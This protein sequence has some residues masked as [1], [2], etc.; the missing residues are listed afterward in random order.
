MQI[1][2]ETG[3]A[4]ILS[5]LVS[6]I[7]PD[8]DLVM[9]QT[10][11]CNLVQD[12]RMHL[13]PN[14]KVWL[15]DIKT[16]EICGQFRQTKDP[17]VLLFK[18]AKI[19]HP[20]TITPWLNNSK[21][22]LLKSDNQW[23]VISNR[24]GYVTIAHLPWYHGQKSHRY[25]KPTNGVVFQS[26]DTCFIAKELNKR[27]IYGYR[28]DKPKEYV[29]LGD[30]PEQQRCTRYF[31]ELFVSR[32]EIVSEYKYKV[33]FK[34]IDIPIIFDD[35]KK[36]GLNKFLPTLENYLGVHALHYRARELSALIAPHSVKDLR[37]LLRVMGSNPRLDTAFSDEPSHYPEIWVRDKDGM[38][39]S[40]VTGYPVSKTL[41]RK[42][43]A[44]RKKL[45][46][47]EQ[48]K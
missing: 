44:I 26:N 3:Q 5:N 22:F 39:E 37:Q 11:S 16:L 18:E 42:C 7:T 29:K 34:C 4:V 1:I 24:L 21:F 47:Q 38:L 35:T 30:L 12:Y 23:Y 6:N 2:S 25:I 36:L 31:N 17:E 20:L 28:K 15:V 43:R 13:S 14:D 40:T 48:V 19:Q 27:G 32:I 10:S 9:Q 8:R 33:H 45:E 46:I 41:E